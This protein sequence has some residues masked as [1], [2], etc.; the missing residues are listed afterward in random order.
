MDTITTTK[1][2]WQIPAK[3]QKATIE[4]FHEMVKTAEDSGFMSYEEYREKLDDWCM[5]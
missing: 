5:L 1:L 4:D 2:N 3:D